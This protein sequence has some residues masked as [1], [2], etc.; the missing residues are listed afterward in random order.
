MQKVGLRTYSLLRSEFPLEITIT[1]EGL[2]VNRAVIGH[3]RVIKDLGVSKTITPVVR[4]DASGMILTSEFKLPNAPQPYDPPPFDVT[5]NIL[6]FFDEGVDA[7]SGYVIS[8]KTR[9]GDEQQTEL[10]PPTVNP[11]SA[12]LKFQ[13]R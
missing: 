4:T 12:L 9:D 11:A 1:A 5:C 7:N 13:V 3:L 8:I 2:R 10:F 6:G